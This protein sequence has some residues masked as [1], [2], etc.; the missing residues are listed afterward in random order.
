[1]TEYED[2]AMSDEESS[3]SLADMQYVGL[4]LGERMDA[5]NRESENPLDPVTRQRAGEVWVQVSKDLQDK[6]ELSEVLVDR[7]SKAIQ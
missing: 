1:M 4:V 3:V 7:L 5:T 6:N 2:F